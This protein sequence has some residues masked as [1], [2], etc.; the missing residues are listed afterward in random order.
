MKV[1]LQR[2]VTAQ[3]RVITETSSK[4]DHLIIESED[5]QEIFDNIPLEELPNEILSCQV[6][7]EDYA[8]AVRHDKV[9]GS[10]S[11]WVV[12]FMCG[13]LD[14]VTEKIS[15]YFSTVDP[16]AWSMDF[17]EMMSETDIRCEL[18]DGCKWRNSRA[19]C[20]EVFKLFIH[21]VGSTDNRSDEFWR[22]LFDI[23][24]P[25]FRMFQEWEREGANFF[26]DGPC[27]QYMRG[28]V[29]MA[30]NGVTLDLFETYMS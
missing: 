25:A 7:Y 5:G 2:W 17:L 11:G 22:I 4:E 10:G 15:E 29:K 12:D 27:P 16:Q 13:Y 8:S 6:N 18:F 19:D 9:C 20:V 26:A 28:V 3:L 30:K 21:R 24:T 1:T 23:F 14:G